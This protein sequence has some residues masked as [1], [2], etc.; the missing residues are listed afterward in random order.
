MIQLTRN[1][2]RSDGDLSALRAEF[3]ANHVLR[4]PALLAPDT[5]Q[6][7][8]LR[9]DAGPWADLRHGKAAREVVLQ[10]AAAL[11]LLHF[12]IGAPDFL[13]IVRRITG[14]DAIKAFGGRI[15]RML[16]IREHMQRWH[17]DFDDRGLRRIALSIN[18]GPRPYQGGLFQMRRA[19]KRKLL[20][21]LPNIAPGHA[22]L[23]RIAPELEHRVTPVTGNE[24]KTAF[25]GWFRSSGSDFLTSIREQSDRAAS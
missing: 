3:D 6:F 25:A 1:G 16:P 5:L 18:L 22:T 23:F 15:Y 13:D 10:D 19:G 21:E 14:C 2:L 8:Q 24:P 4:L 12:M 7:L 17:N 11:H 20:C 9:M